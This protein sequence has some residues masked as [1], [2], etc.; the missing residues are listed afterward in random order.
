MGF[1]VSFQEYLLGMGCAGC[2]SGST[3]INVYIVSA[4]AV[5]TYVILRETFS[6]DDSHNHHTTPPCHG[7][8]DDMPLIRYELMMIIISPR[9][10]A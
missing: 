10:T 2:G 9:Q 1:K 3:P 6:G 8:L 5:G 4:A 7:W